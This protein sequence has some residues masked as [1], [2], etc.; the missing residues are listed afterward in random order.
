MNPSKLSQAVN[1]IPPLINVA[2]AAP[3]PAHFRC[4]AI[5]LTT[6]SA[7]F[8][9]ELYLTPGITRGHFISCQADGGDVYLVFNNA[10]AGA[11]D[12]AI[13]T[14]GTATVCWKIPIGTT[15]DFA[16]PENYTWLVA[17]GS[18]VCKLRIYVSSL[19]DTQ[20]VNEGV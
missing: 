8:N 16:I 10:D 19:A 20:P 3:E 4:A 15:Q 14:A 5:P 12:D 1:I 11:V 18:V 7:R 6:S 17:K 13:T 2:A 9:L